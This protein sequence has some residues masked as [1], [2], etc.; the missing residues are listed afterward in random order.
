MRFRAVLAATGRLKQGVDFLTAHVPVLEAKLAVRTVAGRSL[1]Y[2]DVVASGKAR[3]F[4]A[5]GCTLQ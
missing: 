2:A 5:K 1:A 3:L 4:A